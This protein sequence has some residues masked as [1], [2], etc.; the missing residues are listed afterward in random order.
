MNR[1]GYGRKSALPISVYYPGIR[2]EGLRRATKTSLKIAGVLPSTESGHS[3]YK[4]EVSACSVVTSDSRPHNLHLSDNAPRHKQPEHPELS[5][6]ISWLSPYRVGALSRRQGAS[7]GS[8]WKVS[9][10]I[11]QRAEPLPCNY[12]EI[13]RIYQDRFWAT[14][15]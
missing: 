15:R 7:S 3:L 4:A 14:A 9:S 11:L 1:K 8:G 2:L 5:C 13:R 6:I 10:D 12:R